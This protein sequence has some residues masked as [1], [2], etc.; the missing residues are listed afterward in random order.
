LEP[1]ENALHHQTFPTQITE[2]SLA[3]NQSSALEI[4][5]DVAV[6]RARAPCRHGVEGVWG[7]P[8]AQFCSRWRQLADSR[9]IPPCE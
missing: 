3:V 8:W 2:D 6:L 1:R 5:A 7:F 9:S 4:D